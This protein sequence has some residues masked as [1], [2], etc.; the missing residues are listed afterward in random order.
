MLGFVRALVVDYI[1]GAL[2]VSPLSSY[3]GYFTDVPE[4]EWYTG[5][6]ERAYELGIAVG[7]PDGTFRPDDTLSRQEA[8]AFLMR[9]LE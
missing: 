3:Q 6:V 8:G 2:G 1:L 5:L 9:G 4:G 7:Y